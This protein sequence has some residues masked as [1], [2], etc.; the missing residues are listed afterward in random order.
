MTQ[1]NKLNMIFNPII[2]LN[3]NFK[4]IF[5]FKFKIHDD[6]RKKKTLK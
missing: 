1:F 2:K 4:V 6:Q 3:Q 5:P